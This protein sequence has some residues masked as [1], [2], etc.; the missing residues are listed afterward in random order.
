MTVPC[1]RRKGFAR[2][3]ELIDGV[4]LY[5]HPMSE[6]RNSPFGPRTAAHAFWE[7][8]YAWWIY[9]RR[10]FHVIQ[11]CNPPD[12]IFLI[13]LS[14]RILGVRYVFDRHDANP[15]LYLSKVEEKTC[16]TNCRLGLVTHRFSDVVM[17][18]NSSYQDLAIS[19]G[20]IPPED[21][22]AHR[23]G[24]DAKTF[25]A[26]ADFVRISNYRSNNGEYS[27]IFW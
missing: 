16:S 19:R 13:A 22:F 20:K 9:L 12:D 7:F 10:G 23:T 25:K 15:K 18:T 27:G 2:K 5:R 8:F 17:A 3:H 21:V 11:G 24:P 1:P 14:F 6:E 26:V 4:Y